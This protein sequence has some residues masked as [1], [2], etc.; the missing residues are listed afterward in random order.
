MYVCMY[1]GWLGGAICVIVVRY[2]GVLCCTIAPHAR[3]ASLYPRGNVKLSV[4]NTE[5]PKQVNP[6]EWLASGSSGVRVA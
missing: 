4:G 3:P 6:A 2:G 1:A 5:G